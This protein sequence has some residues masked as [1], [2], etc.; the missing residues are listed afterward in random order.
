MRPLDRFGRLVTHHQPSHP[1]WLP[2][3]EALV[4]FTWVQR[5]TLRAGDFRV[6]V[7]G[8]CYYQ[9]AIEVACR[10][11][12][13]G[14]P[15]VPLVTAYLVREPDNPHDS[16]G[17][18]VDVGGRCVG[19]ISRHTVVG[20][21]AVLADL[22][23]TGRD[24][25][26]RGWLTGGWDARDRGYFGLELDL[27]RDLEAV[28]NVA[29]LPFGHR[30]IPIIGADAAQDHLW[31]LVEDGVRAE[32]LAVLGEPAG[33]IQ[34]FIGDQKV[35]QLTPEMSDRYRPW[36][37]EVMVAGMEPS[38]EARVIPGPK[39]VEVY[40]KLAEPWEITG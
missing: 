19:Y 24:A 22:A 15:T 32:V 8:E 21:H 18:R 23:A 5:P 6:V 34:V 25:I 3:R 11:E 20:F 39:K 33:R 38:C 26:C 31:S 40:L 30:R 10:V 7:V 37:A 27:H 4:P 12:A 14:L 36:V 28:E 17:V 35:G 13:T 16:N 2:H 9:D 29:I 1:P